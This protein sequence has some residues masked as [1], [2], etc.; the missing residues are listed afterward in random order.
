MGK[1]TA[2]NMGL[3]LL[4]FSSLGHSAMCV[5]K[6]AVSQAVGATMCHM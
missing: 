2:M 5:L 1:K 3:K 6:A 4:D